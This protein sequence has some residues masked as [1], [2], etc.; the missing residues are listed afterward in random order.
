MITEI[1]SFQKS[2]L[3]Y[4]LQRPRSTGNPG[5]WYQRL[6]ICSQSLCVVDRRLRLARLMDGIR[7]GHHVIHI[8]IPEQHVLWLGP[9][10][11]HFSC[12]GVTVK[13][14]KDILNFDEKSFNSDS[15]LQTGRW[16]SA[17]S[18]TLTTIH[19]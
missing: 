16:T 19:I 11:S 17:G 4:V 13:K 15:L 18:R 10:S 3:S 7:F 5:N 1:F 12:L 2:P 8:V 6:S 9:H 14:E